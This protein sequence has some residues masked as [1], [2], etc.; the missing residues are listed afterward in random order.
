MCEFL[1]ENFEYQTKVFNVE[2]FTKYI[3]TVFEYVLPDVND[4]SILQI[5][6]EE[7]KLFRN[8]LKK[9]FYETY[10]E[11]ND[12]IF[13]LYHKIKDLFKQNDIVYDSSK[14]TIIEKLK[15]YMI[16]NINKTSLEC[17]ICYNGY[18]N[19]ALIHDSHACVVCKDCAEKFTKKS[20]PFCKKYTKNCLKLIYP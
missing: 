18:A 6:W 3:K 15:E 10:E 17:K 1:I 19:H 2:K 7:F 14:C 12:N 8:V 4:I 13:N 16:E 9:C 11:V 20:C 5:F